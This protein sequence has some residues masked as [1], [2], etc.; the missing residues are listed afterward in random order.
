MHGALSYTGSTFQANSIN[1]SKE[2]NGKL[3]KYDN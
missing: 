2:Q 1:Q 3:S